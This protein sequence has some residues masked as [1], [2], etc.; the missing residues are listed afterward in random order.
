MLQNQEN[1]QEINKNKKQQYS[2]GIVVFVGII[3]L[4]LLPF[5]LATVVAVI[6]F[7]VVGY[8]FFGLYSYLNKRN[9]RRVKLEYKNNTHPAYLKFRYQIKKMSMGK[10]SIL[11]DTPNFN[12]RTIKK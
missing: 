7:A 2:N 9:Q 8:I 10:T 4:V 12:L 11:E 5:V 1:E 6:P 3:A